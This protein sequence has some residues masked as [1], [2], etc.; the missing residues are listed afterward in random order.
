MQADVG[1]KTNSSRKKQKPCHLIKQLTFKRHYFFS[2]LVEMKLN[3]LAKS[4][5][6]NYTAQQWNCC[7]ITGYTCF[8]CIFTGWTYEYNMH[9]F[10]QSGQVFA[11]EHF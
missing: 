11:L 1:K 2:K 6:Q 8:L 5:I 9:S 7:F 3:P 10:V 4:S